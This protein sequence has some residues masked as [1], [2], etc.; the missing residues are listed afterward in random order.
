MLGREIDVAPV[1]FRPLCVVRKCTGQAALI[2]RHAR[3]DRDVELAAGRKQFILRILIEDV[4]DDLHGIDETGPH[5][6]DDVRRLPAIHADAERGDQLLPLQ[7]FGRAFPAFVIDPRVVP[8]VQLLKIKSACS[9]IRKTLLSHL[10]DVFGREDLSDRRFG[11]TW[12]LHVFWWN[13]RCRVQLRAGMTLQRFAEQ[14]LAAS[15]SICVRRIEE[16]A[17]ELDRA[18]ERSARLVIVRASPSAHT[19]HAIADFRH[20]PAKPAE[21]SVLHQR[22]ILRFDTAS[23]KNRSLVNESFVVNGRYDVSCSA[24]AVTA[25]HSAG[26]NDRSRSTEPP[27]FSK[28]KPTWTSTAKSAPDSSTRAPFSKTMHS[29]P[30]TSMKTSAGIPY[31]SARSSSVTDSTVMRPCAPDPSSSCPSRL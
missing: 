16:I 23:R 2:E 14:L 22:S 21:P 7:L 4:V 5:R 24:R 18:I 28:P 1:T 9:E 20:L 17:A 12:P 8:H 10:D 30:S 6:L 31:F 15:H 3:D 11:T 27:S 19:P 26:K 25:N 13:F 29:A